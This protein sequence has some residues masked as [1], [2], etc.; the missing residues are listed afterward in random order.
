M[1]ELKQAYQELA[2]TAHPYADADRAIRTSRRRQV[3]QGVA[4]PAVAALIIGI[5][6]VTIGQPGS[7]RTAP[8]SPGPSQTESLDS[9]SMTDW[10]PSPNM[11]GAPAR[12]GTFLYRS[13]AGGDCSITLVRPDGQTFD[14]ADVYP[15]LATRLNPN[16]L[17]GVSLSYSAQTLGYPEDDG[18]YTLAVGDGTAVELPAGPAGATWKV[19]GWGEASWSLGLALWQD[20]QVI[21]Y[22]SVE[23]YRLHTYRPPGDLGML[24]VES[25]GYLVGLSAPVDTSLSP[26]DRPR[27][28][29][30]D[31]DSLSVSGGGVK[32]GAIEP[33]D[34]PEDF[35]PCL[36]P[37]ETL[38]G[39]LGVPVHSAT[40][41][42]RLEYGS[43]TGVG[44]TTVFRVA[45]AK[46]VPSAIIRGWSCPSDVR[47]WGRYDLPQS[48]ATETWTFLSVVAG[49]ESAMT[50]HAEGSSG[51]DVVIVGPE[52]K[53]QVVGTVPADAQVLMP[54][55]TIP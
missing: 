28:T 24:P 3:V 10:V 17:S 55:M 53:H 1:K 54:G 39:P 12:T 41:P 29:I 4:V 18:S 40:P 43:S 46:L 30:L 36:R 15:D 22:A 42:S 44:V 9:A 49:G 34:N 50:R 14:F 35:S 51:K 8:A 13:C 27:V 19:I 33:E 2:E 23:N 38:A 31:V 5:L 47:G 6:A 45:D 32:A 52:G 37:A 25:G 11:I 48:T 20:E 7:N 16:D 26:S 21:E